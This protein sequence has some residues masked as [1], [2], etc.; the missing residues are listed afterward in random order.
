[1]NWLLYSI[2]S[3]AALNTVIH[4]IFVAVGLSLAMITKKNNI[5]KD[6]TKILTNY[7]VWIILAGICGL[8]G[9]VFLYWAY[10][11]GDDVNP[12]IIATMS[13]VAIVISTLLAYLVY[14]AKITGKQGLG[15]LVTVSY[16]H[17]TLPT[18]LLV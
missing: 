14:D 8:F 16:T 5:L 17:L 12:G 7:S 3:S 11:L 6:F 13:N 10:V 9:N 15:M 4:T 18:I 2:I 1:M